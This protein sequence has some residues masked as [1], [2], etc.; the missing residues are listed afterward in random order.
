MSKNN[1]SFQLHD[2]VSKVHTEQKFL[3]NTEYISIQRKNN[4]P[5]VCKCHKV[6][7]YTGGEGVEHVQGVQVR[8][9]KEFGNIY[10]AGLLHCGS[11]WVCPICAP[12]IAEQRCKEIA[13]AFNK[14][15]DLGEKNK[16]NNSQVMVS[17][18]IPHVS[19]QSLKTLRKRFMLSRRNLKKQQK[20]R[21]N[22]SLQVYS[23]LKKKYKIKGIIS[24]IEVT[25]GFNGWHPHSH[26]IF[27]LEEDLSRSDLEIFRTEL[28]SAWI[29]ACKRSKVKMNKQQ[30]KAM[31]DHSVKISR[32]ATAEQYISKFGI[33]EYEKNK[34]VLSPGWGAAQELSKNHIKLSYGQEGMTPWQMLKLIHDN[35]DDYSIYLK[36]GALFYE[37]S[38]VFRGRQQIFWSKNFKNFLNLTDYILSDVDVLWQ[39]SVV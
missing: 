34:D 33:V 37:Y 16:T 12:R 18:T 14:W 7:L 4:Q 26:D 3:T 30:E 27:F 13:L 21:K 17:F 25:Y 9:N 31:Y 38:K 24:A 15:E 2:I 1:L 32:A 28:T 20:L 10:F 8:K 11:A 6:P 35:P 39:N 5:R 36:Y 23:D 22:P 29:Y 19:D